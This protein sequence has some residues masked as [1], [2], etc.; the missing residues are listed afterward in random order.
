MGRTSGTIGDDAG[1]S[2]ILGRDVEQVA[3]ILGASRSKQLPLIQIPRRRKALSG[4]RAI[5]NGL[6]V[7]SR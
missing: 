2:P 5:L 1:L 6:A 4:A 3:G 7:V